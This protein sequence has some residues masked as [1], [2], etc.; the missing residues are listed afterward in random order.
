LTSD[1]F[2]VWF[3][4]I[5]QQVTDRIS[6]DEGNRGNQ[7]HLPEIVEEVRKLAH[8]FPLWTAVMTESFAYGSLTAST[9][10]VE[11]SFNDVKNRMVKHIDMPARV[12]EFIQLHVEYIDGAMKLSLGKTAVRQARYVIIYFICSEVLL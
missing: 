5:V 8:L 4:T 2:K 1:S 3:N 7:Q 9:A 11:G 6:G 10:A 12:D